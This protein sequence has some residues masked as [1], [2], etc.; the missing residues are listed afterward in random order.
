MS[1]FIRRTTISGTIGLRDLIAD[2][3]FSRR[4]SPLC[5][6]N[7]FSS[8]AIPLKDGGV[9]L[10]ARHLH[11]S[12]IPRVVKANYNVISLSVVYAA[13]LYVP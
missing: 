10:S 6:R 13:A 9:N 4:S 1:Y 7:S 5:R 8:R 2:E 3:R 12:I 11:S